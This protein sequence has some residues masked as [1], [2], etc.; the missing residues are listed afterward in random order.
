MLLL[1][2]TLRSYLARIVGVWLVC[3]VSVL[4]AASLSMA[5]VLVNAG[6]HAVMCTCGTAGPD[7]D[8]PMHGKHTDHAA[9]DHAAT[10]QKAPDCVIR[11]GSPAPEATLASLFVGI[12]VVPPTQ[13]AA[14]ADLTVES[15]SAL[16]APVLLRSERP[17]SP[18]P[19]SHNR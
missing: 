19:R 17:D 6:D 13:S 8:C 12:G 9:T 7:H 14:A 1:V 15:L 3:Q 16:P 11:S 5:G 4:A 10:G 18:P 2:R